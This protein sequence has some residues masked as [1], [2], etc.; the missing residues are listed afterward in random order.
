MEDSELTYLI[1]K[2][3]EEMKFAQ[4]AEIALLEGLGNNILEH[5]GNVELGRP[6]RIF[7]QE[8]G[9]KVV[10][11]AIANCFGGWM[12]ISLLWVEKSLR[13][14]GYGCRLLELAETEAIKMG[15]THAHVDTYSFEA[16]PFYEKYGYLLFATLDEYPPGYCKYFLKKQLVG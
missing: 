11:G 15:N 7:I 10:G 6:I 14:R 13:N 8:H 4:E 5:L 2:S 9:G 12:Y 16:R 1:C 3:P